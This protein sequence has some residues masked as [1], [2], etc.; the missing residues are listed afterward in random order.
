[1]GCA[2]PPFPG[3][4]LAAIASQDDPKRDWSAQVISEKAELEHELQSPKQLL[5]CD[6]NPTQI[7]SFCMY[8]LRMHVVGTGGSG[9]SAIRE[10]V[11]FKK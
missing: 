3:V 7:H 1:M 5:A 11:Y 4:P 10:G 6:Y 2:S 9:T 8:A